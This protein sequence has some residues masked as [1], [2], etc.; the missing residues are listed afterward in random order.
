[1]VHVCRWCNTAVR[2]HGFGEPVLRVECMNCGER[3]QEITNK[4]WEHWFNTN[5][6]EEV[7]T[8]EERASDSH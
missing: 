8:D 3:M 1:M 7:R 5:N 4:E 2:L 6:R